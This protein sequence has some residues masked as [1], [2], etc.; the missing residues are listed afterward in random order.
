MQQTA[1]KKTATLT[2]AS[3]AGSVVKKFPKEIRAVAARML[4]KKVATG[5]DVVPVPATKAISKS[6]TVPIMNEFSEKYGFSNVVLAEILD[7]SLKTLSRYQANDKPLSVQQKDRIKMVE[8]ILE[9]G[10]RVLGDESEVKSWLSRP[11]YSIENK[12][13]IELIVS[14]SGRR[15]VE[16]VLLQIEGGAY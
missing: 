6:K 10:K 1:S 13:P 15:R 2:K 11:V 16:N 3:K 9:L 7:V 4:T 14:E 12:K 8:S 5:K